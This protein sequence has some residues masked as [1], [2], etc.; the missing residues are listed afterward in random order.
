MRVTVLGATGGIGRS[1]VAELNRRGHDVT[2]ASRSTVAGEVPAGVTAR[3]TAVGDPA[4]A[5][6]ACDG[7]DVV[8]M[9][10]NVPYRHWPARLRPLVDSALA[11]AVAARARFVMVDN[12]Y[13]YG[14]PG[15]P[16]TDRTP[17][18][19]T[20]RKGIL[21]RGLV[22]HLLAEHRDGRARVAVGR[23][24]DYYGPAP[25]QSSIP[26]SLA[27]QRIIE[28]KPP[29]AFIATDQPHTFHYLPDAA[30]GF[31]T[32]VERPAADGRS[33][34]LPAEPALTQRE[35]L[36]L[37]TAAAGRPPAMGRVTPGMLWLAGLVNPQ[38][39]EARE[40]V[41]QFDRPYLVQADDFEAAFGPIETTPHDRAAAETI[42]Y[43]RRGA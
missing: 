18:A 12:L 24:S 30:R 41:E 43:F 22:E 29:R 26:N 38:L 40:V 42:A 31:A 27:V 39:R 35:L 5:R 6:A 4:A 19:A 11:A 8:V 15:T 34:I 21:R 1:I 14:S 17:E 37:L 32:L 3:I 20:T 25:Y 36:E 9:A 13:A 28:G 10:V 2:A 23:C 33:W 7:S 16:I